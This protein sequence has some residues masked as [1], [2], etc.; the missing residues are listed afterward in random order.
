[1]TSNF[2]QTFTTQIP[3]NLVGFGTQDSSTNDIKDR[4][5]TLTNQ[6]GEL[7]LEV[8][9]RPL[10]YNSQIRDLGDEA[11]NLLEPLLIAI[12]E[13]PGEDITIASFPEIEAFGEGVTE[14]DAILS[15][16]TAIL[17]LYDE[18]KDTPSSTLGVLPRSWWNVLQKIIST[19]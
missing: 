9:D 3:R 8:M 11:Y 12:E 7:K 2:P 4:L 5:E 13:Y 6:T 14:A 10:K 18:L 17:D 19:E 1:M 16:K 15:L